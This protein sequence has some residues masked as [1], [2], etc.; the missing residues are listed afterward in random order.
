MT[1]DS[2]TV[3]ENIYFLAKKKG[4]KVGELEEAAGVG[5]GYFSRFLKEPE[6]P[7]EKVRSLPSAEVL[8]AVCEKLDITLDMLLHTDYQVLDDVDV[9]MALFFGK[10]KEATDSNAL[11]WQKLT[12]EELL[13]VVENN[14]LLVK[15]VTQKQEKDETTGLPKTETIYIYKSMFLKEYSSFPDI[16]LSLENKGLRLLV[17]QTKSGGSHYYYETYAINNGQIDKLS[18]SRSGLFNRMTELEKA[19]TDLFRSAYKNAE[20][21]PRGK[22]I[23]K[24]IDDYMNHF[25]FKK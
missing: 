20:V 9:S 4:I 11:I 19:V 15:E 7:D 3:V 16:I 14:P 12:I 1:L 18:W 2:K 21:N 25:G 6:S 13:N 5:S 23:I 22:D 8:E 17:I 10:L 24:L